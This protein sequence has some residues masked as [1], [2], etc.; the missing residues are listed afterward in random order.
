MLTTKAATAKEIFFSKNIFS[1]GKETLIF[2]LHESLINAMTSAIINICCYGRKCYS[3]SKAALEMN[4]KQATAVYAENRRKEIPS[5]RCKHLWLP[6]LG[7][8][9]I[10]MQVCFPS[11]ILK[12]YLLLVIIKSLVKYLF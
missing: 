9:F 3:E 1:G 2:Q 4:L 5:L 7:L 6:G 8:Q 12:A 11:N 10:L